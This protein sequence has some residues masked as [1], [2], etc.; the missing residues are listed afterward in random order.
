[1]EKC[2]YCGVELV[3]SHQAPQALNERTV[4]HVIP[5]SFLRQLGLIHLANNSTN[6]VLAC[7]KCNMEKGSRVPSDD[8]LP[9]AVRERMKLLQ[10]LPLQELITVQVPVREGLFF[11]HSNGAMT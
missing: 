4:D 1:M 3:R 10:K 5:K 6:K 2:F 11:L 9:Q 7:H 8:E